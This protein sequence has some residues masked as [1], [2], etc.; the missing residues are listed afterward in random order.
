MKKWFYVLELAGG[1]HYVG[2]SNNVVRRARQ[3]HEGKGAV[4][5]K[6]HS[7]MNVLFQHEHDVPDEHT[8][9]NIE[10]EMTVKLMVEHGWKKVR[11]GY[12]CAISDVEVE[13]AL[14]S[15]GYWDQVL[16]STVQ[17]IS[18]TADWNE[19]V[20]QIL[21]Q[22]IAFHQSGCS[23]SS[24]DLLLTTL[25]GLTRHR[26]WRA[27]FSPGLEET[28]WGPRGV[29]RV[30]LS[31]KLDQPVGYKLQDSFAVLCAGMQMGRGGHQPWTHLFLAAW[32]GY[33]PSATEVQQQ[34]VQ[35]WLSDAS[36]RQPDRR[37]DEFTSLLLPELRWRLRDTGDQA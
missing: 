36:S 2:I 35:A 17:I 13:K 33:A 27:D 34:R 20:L 3:H 30:L 12:F 19:S 23:D 10:N 31:L 21:E 22:S 24:R 26:L 1:R 29:L 14:R 7:P 8:A 16:Q 4:W 9:Y 28:F 18:P 6:L 25:L 15:H 5:T 32:E 37:F 11:G